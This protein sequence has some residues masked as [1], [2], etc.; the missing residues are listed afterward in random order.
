MDPRS[1]PADVPADA[2]A[3]VPADAPADVPARVPAELLRE[4]GSAA[5]PREL[6]GAVLSAAERIS[7]CPNVALRLVHGPHGWMPF[8]AAR[9]LPPDFLKDEAILLR[10][11][12][13]CGRVIRGDVDPGLD[14]F[15]RSG[16][17]RHGGLQADF[18]DEEL[19]LFGTV[20]G[21]CIGMGYMTVVL[22]PIKTEDRV[23]GM[24]YLSSDEPNAV[25]DRTLLKLE[26]LC[27]EVAPALQAMSADDRERETSRLL[28]DALAPEP[29]ASVGALEIGASL[30]T[31]GSDALLGGD[32]CAALE[33]R[34]G[35][36][37]LFVGDV[38]GEGIEVAGLAAHCRWTLTRLVQGDPPLAGAAKLLA[39]ADGL[40]APDMP[41]ERFATVA[42]AI[43]DP[44]ARRLDVA[45]AGHPTPT[46]LREGAEA[47]DVGALGPPLGVDSSA[48]F[49]A[50]ELSVPST[51]T[52]VMCTDGV[53]DAPGSGGRFG[54]AG[55]VEAIESAAGSRPADLARRVLDMAASHAGPRRTDDMLAMAA[56]SNG[57]RADRDEDDPG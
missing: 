49:A 41:E 50:A 43:F 7:G 22:L 17:F 5:G 9:G 15:T 6:F 55:L 56:R 12:C 2:P 18:T 44:R 42:L 33:L 35:R 47:E 45:L 48:S 4:I 13:M 31:A 21:R 40:L 30:R 8:V 19:R 32:F 10:G 27:R 14:F 11:E 16:G 34:D 20:R 23:V 24:L 25:D 46:L 54:R 29:Q 37:L 57:T 52:L 28:K 53:L 39:A 3:D 51:W 38:A 36:V 26:A 1:R